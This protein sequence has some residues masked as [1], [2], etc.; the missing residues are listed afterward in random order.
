MAILLLATVTVNAQQ[1]YTIT[2]MAEFE[3]PWEKTTGVIEVTAVALNILCDGVATK[4]IVNHNTCIEGN[5]TKDGIP[6]TF[7]RATLVHTNVKVPVQLIIYDYN[8][9]IMFAVI[10]RNDS[11]DTMYYQ[12]IAE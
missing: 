11:T 4:V 8:I 2:H 1:F 6:Y 3:E 9:S 7:W 12:A 10:N 5:T